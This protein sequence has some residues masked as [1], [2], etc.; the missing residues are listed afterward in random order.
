[1][2]KPVY[3]PQP[4][5]S[6]VS[7]KPPE[8]IAHR[9]YALRYPE[10][11]MQSL[12]AAIDLGARY[13][14]FDVQLT[15]EGVPVLLHDTNLWRTAGIDR[16][17]LDMTLDD[18]MRVE[19][20]E[21]ARFGPQFS[22]VHVP[23]LGEIP[24]LLKEHPNVTAFVELKRGSVARF[25]VD[26]VVGRSLEALGTTIER[27]VVISF[28]EAAVVAARFAGAATG[29]ILEEWSAETQAALEEL[30]PEYVFCDYRMIPDDASL[31]PGPWRWAMY[32][33]IEPD[34]ALGLAAFG[35]HFVETMAIREMLSDRRLISASRRR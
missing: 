30:R 11:T 8:L 1:M 3:L 33:V 27:C 20:N 17:V 12:R 26:Q 31:W 9:G 25:G 6:G 23:L 13:I 5:P 34:L 2:I 28:D 7:I 29:W 10:N 4:R 24:E 14:E 19:V 32:E 15:A 35:A 21:A 18:V 16:S 22:G